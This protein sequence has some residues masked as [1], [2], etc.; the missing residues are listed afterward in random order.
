MFYECGC[1]FRFVCSSIL[2]VVL[3]FFAIVMSFLISTYIKHGHAGRVHQI[4]D[5]N[6]ESTDFIMHVCL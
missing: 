5:A 1:V 4:N 2:C 6:I 3:I